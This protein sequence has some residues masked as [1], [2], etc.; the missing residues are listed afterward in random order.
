MSAPVFARFELVSGDFAVVNPIHVTTLRSTSRET[1]LVFVV[2]VPD[3]L[4]ELFNALPC[5]LQLESL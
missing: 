5:E 2:G 1:T 3:V 4:G